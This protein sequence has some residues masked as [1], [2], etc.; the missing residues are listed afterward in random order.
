MSYSSKFLCIVVLLVGSQQVQAQDPIEISG[1]SF[2]D[3]YYVL[4]SPSEDEEDRNGFTFR[5]LYLTA[6][7]L[8]GSGFSGRARLEAGNSNVGSRGM[9]PFVKDLYLRWRSNGGHSIRLGII[10]IPHWGTS[11]DVWAYRS[12]EQTVLDLFGVA[13]SRDMGI[14]VDGPLMGDRLGYSVMVGNNNGTRPEDDEGKRFYGQLQSRPLESLVVTAGF[15]YAGYVDERDDGLTLHLFAG[16]DLGSATVGVEP[17][18]NRIDYSPMFVDPGGTI[19]TVTT[20]GISLF[21]HAAV[22]PSWRVIGRV[23]LA[24]VVVDAA[25]VGADDS[26]VATTFG[27]AA[28]SYSPTPNV[29][30]MPNVWIQST[31]DSDAEVLGRFTF[32]Y[33]F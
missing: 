30:L 16:Y 4:S 17:F 8:L 23:D 15:D 13:S 6:D 29:Q 9:E 12:L 21:A 14:R 5:R 3:Y 28:V 31:Q 27:L 10:P 24:E 25:A 19:S 22:A 20:S 18:W 33:S 11:E 7:Y 1:T 26:S 32:A 2:G